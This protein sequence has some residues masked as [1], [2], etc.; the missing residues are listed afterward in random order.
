MSDEP[1]DAA[2]LA[3]YADALVASIEV[4]LGPWLVRQ[5]VERAPSLEAEARLAAAR[6]VETTIPEL[7]A[8]LSTDID[9]Q[10]ATPLQVVREATRAVTAVLMAGGVAPPERDELART[11]D[12]RD[13]Y[14]LG[15]ASYADLGPEVAEAGLVWGAAKAHVHLARRRKL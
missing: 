10:R 5:V 4:S 12:R 9:Q 6:A 8:L 1:S 13:L 2:R 7:R 11:I 15:P 14:D 3:A